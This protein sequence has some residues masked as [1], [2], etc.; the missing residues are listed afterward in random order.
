[1]RNWPQT[2]QVDGY[3]SSSKPRVSCHPALRK[4]AVSC[5]RA[6]GARQPALKKES[7]PPSA[8][9]RG[10][11]DDC[12][13]IAERWVR[14]RLPFESARRLR[15]AGFMPAVR[16]PHQ[17]ARFNTAIPQARSRRVG[18]DSSGNAKVSGATK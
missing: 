18:G 11:L 17:A 8:L 7:P 4:A 10:V 6:M 2:K 5:S 13:L 15:A 12:M 14:M 1:G 16:P 3:T 9:A